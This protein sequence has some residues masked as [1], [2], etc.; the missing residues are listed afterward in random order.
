MR[1]V[2]FF[3]CLRC[4]ILIH[5]QISQAAGS[6]Y[7]SLGT[8]RE[9]AS[10]LHVCVGS[11]LRCRAV[12]ALASAATALGISGYSCHLVH[13][14]SGSDF[15]TSNNRASHGAAAHSAPTQGFVRQNSLANRRERERVRE[16][17]CSRTPPQP[18]RPREQTAN[19]RKQRVFANAVCGGVRECKTLFSPE[20]LC[21]ISY[22]LE[23]GLEGSVQ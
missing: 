4:R 2:S 15:R 20:N 9:P 19:K 6:P 21:V 7:I 11:T 8:L 22:E 13:T 12:T 5:W 10:T 14:D 18:A 3:R 23:D 17:G 16:R 1:S